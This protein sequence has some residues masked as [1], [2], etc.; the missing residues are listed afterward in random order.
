MFGR[1]R[2]LVGRLKASR[3][4]R[5]YFRYDRLRGN[6]LAGAVSFYGFVALFPLLIIAA[7]VIGRALGRD[8]AADLQEIVEENLPGIAE[9]LNVQGF[10][11][12]A[13]TIGLVSGVLL[14]WTGLSWVDAARAAVRSMWEKDDQPGN[15]VM[16][17]ALDVLALAGL[18]LVLAVSWA[19]S[20]F[21]GS[22]ADEIF[23]EL[24]FGIGAVLR[25]VLALSLA[26]LSSSVLFAYLLTGLPRV[27]VPWRVL[28]PMALIGGLVFELLKQVVTH[29]A[30]VVAPDNTYAAFAVPLALLAWIYLVTRLLMLLAA[31]SAEWASDQ[32]RH[33]V[34]VQAA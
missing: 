18:G 12:R 11:D 1:A 23:D 14:L 32:G 13:G 27:R 26:I 34:V 33:T 19:A 31:F 30:V 29:F 21:V 24:G 28:V 6:R 5:A 4:V 9:S 15:V 16:R 7:A 10:I 2:Q 17:K 3:P 20:V 8:R 25:R 22:A